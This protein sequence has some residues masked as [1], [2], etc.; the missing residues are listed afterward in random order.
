MVDHPSDIADSLL[1][2]LLAAA[3]S[4][5]ALPNGILMELES[6]TDALRRI[7]DVVERERH[8]CTFLRFQLEVP[9]DGEAFVVSVTGPEGTAELLANFATLALASVAV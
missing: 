9:P 8:R 6:T 4:L 3:R 7:A 2:G 5:T 1:P